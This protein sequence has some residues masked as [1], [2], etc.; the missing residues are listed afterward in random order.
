MHNRDF[1]VQIFFIQDLAGAQ[2]V[3]GIEQQVGKLKE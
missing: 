2:D 1:Y 3:C